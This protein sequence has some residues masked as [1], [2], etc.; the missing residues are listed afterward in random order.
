MV[1][2]LLDSGIETGILLGSGRYIGPQPV[3]WYALA[4]KPTATRNQGT[5]LCLQVRTNKIAIAVTVR[6]LLVV[7]V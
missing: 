1:M 2:V 6:T 3:S 5:G 7:A 4:L